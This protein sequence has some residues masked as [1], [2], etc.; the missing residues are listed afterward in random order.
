MSSEY[1]FVQ[2]HSI[3]ELQSNKISDKCG[4]C[5]GHRRL[6]IGHDY[7]PCYSCYSNDKITRE[8]STSNYSSNTSLTSD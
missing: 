1:S 5:S 8:N 4:L 2:I 6:Y 3:T 7:Q